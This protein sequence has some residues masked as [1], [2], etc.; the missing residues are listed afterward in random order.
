MAATLRCRRRHILNVVSY[1][2]DQ[3][4][5]NNRYHKRMNKRKYKIYSRKETPSVEE[6]RVL[7]LCDFIMWRIRFRLNKPVVVQLGIK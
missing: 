5:D 1:C 4:I 3:L 6:D 2:C 7:I